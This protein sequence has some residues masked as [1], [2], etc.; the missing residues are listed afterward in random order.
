MD[1]SP[2]RYRK[3]IFDAWRELHIALSMQR[4]LQQRINDLRELIRANANFLPSGERQTELVLLDVFRPPT[5]IAEAVRIALIVAK[6]EKKTGLTPVQVREK[7]ETR[8]F[9]F[10]E[11]NNPLAS[12]HTI[13][14]RMKEA[15]EVEYDERSGA[16]LLT[17]AGMHGQ[18]LA[19][20]LAP[21][22][23]EKLYKNVLNRVVDVA[24]GIDPKRVDAVIEE[25]TT[26]WVDEFLQSTKRAGSDESHNME[27]ATNLVNTK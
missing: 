14:R 11:Y 16:F 22:A 3:Q 21:G 6:A 15:G 24:K 27:S 1:L 8:G 4:T 10:S 25:I 5:N 7:A 19:G 17:E 26:A 12:I 2:D 23:M 18:S 20:L 13:L 9:D